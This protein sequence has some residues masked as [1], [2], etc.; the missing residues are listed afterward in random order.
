[1]A[2]VLG[3]NVGDVDS[4]EGTVFVR[5][6]GA[7]DRLVPI[8]P[9]ALA[10]LSGYFERRTVRLRKTTPLFTVHGFGTEELG[11][12]DENGLW[13]L[14]RRLN[15]DFHRHVHPHLLRHTFAVHLLKNG[16]DL[17]YVQALL[18]HESPDTTSMY[19]GLVKEE[20]KRDYDRAIGIILG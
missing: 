13:A 16:A 14:F 19:L 8:N 6:K 10:A 20:L 17:R 11:R 3:L 7:K 18:G 9:S 12:F 2:E 1:M 5:G 15:R 4:L